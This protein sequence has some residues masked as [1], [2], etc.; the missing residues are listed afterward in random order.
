M[1]KLTV[2]KKVRWS[3]NVSLLILFVLLV[4]V[5]GKMIMAHEKLSTYKEAIKLYKAGKLAAAEEKF[6]AAKLN[7]FVTDHNK[8]INQK[9]SILSPIRKGIEEFDEKAANYYRDQDLNKLVETYENWQGSKKNWVSG[10]SVQKE[11]YEEMVALTKLDS[12]MKGYFTSFKKE[13]F[14]K[15]EIDSANVISEEE[16]IFNVLHKI[17]AE[18]YGKSSSAKTKEIETAFI[19]YYSTK[20]NKEIETGLASSI[21]DEGIRQFT[22]LTVLSLDSNWLVETLDSHLLEIV[23]ASINK[24]DYAAFAEAAITIKRLEGNMKN[25]EVFSY[26]ESATVESLDRAEQL[27]AAHKYEDALKI[28]EELKPL[29]DTTKLVASTNLAWDKYE[30]IRVLERLYPGKEF[31]KVVKAS[32]K[33]GADSVVAAIS[34]DGGLYF[35]RLTGEEPMMVTEDTMEGAPAINQLVFQSGLSSSDHPVLYIDAKSSERKHHYL[36]YEVSGNSMV[37]ILDVEADG[38]TIELDQVLVVDNP[39]GQ[40]EGELAYFEPDDNGKYQFSKTKETYVEINVEDLAN[41]YGKKVRFSAHTETQQD[42]GMLVTLS[43]NF[44]EETETWEKTYLL[45]K[46]Y[47]EFTTNTTYTISGVFDSYS[48][49]VDENG[50]TVR[51]PVFQVEKVE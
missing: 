15:L 3:R 32:K 18:Y 25:A 11:M 7:I 46:G 37:N 35:G 26:I 2:Y 33:F 16:D 23:T 30:P 20:I 36:A 45:L 48:D 49:I 19:K 22:A 24:K 44:N 9:L 51:V 27:T 1:F 8:D 4:A 5:C 13:S 21:V 50:E 6:Q 34:T 40:G 41:Y 39:V 43:V 31:S 10:T 17:P 29:D 28:Y 47:S 14:G 42:D 38:L 12:E